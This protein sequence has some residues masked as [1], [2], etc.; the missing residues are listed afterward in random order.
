MLSK[1]VFGD[2]LPTWALFL[3]MALASVVVI[4]T[5][6]RLTRLADTLANR[7]NL[8]SGWVGLILLATVTSLPELIS[9][10]TATW[11]GNVDLAL[12]GILGSCSFNIT[13]IVLLN[14][15]LRRGSV[16]RG[17][18]TSHALSSSF[19]LLL[20]GMALIGIVLTDKF[21]DRPLAA[22]V[23]EIA[24]AGAILVTYIGCMMLSYK[25]ARRT[26][27]MASKDD[28]CSTHAE[29]TTVENGLYGRVAMLAAIIAAA[30]WWLAQVAD[31]LSTHEI[32]ILGRPLGATFVGVFF[33]AFATS[34]PE[35]TTSV[36]A[37]R[38]GNLDLALGNIFGSNMFNIFVIPILKTVSLIRGDVL[39]IPAGTVDTTQNLIAGLLAVLLTAIAVAGLTY[40]STRKMLRHFGLDSI[41]I[42][43][44]Y[45]GGMVL[46][47]MESR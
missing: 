30:S 17:V 22:Q 35:I 29:T 31:T 47:L 5:G 1:L 43:V 37:V 40:Q 6:T 3:E 12:G 18:S 38:L 33:L 2:T 27:S 4:W 32:A 14:A 20:L 34:L 7:L 10:G 24:W 45:L 42:A 16:L 26:A 46:L 21:R 8:G 25:F 36:A 13:I 9:G 15:L 39:M 11:I 19:G 28:L 44:T 41:L 23:C